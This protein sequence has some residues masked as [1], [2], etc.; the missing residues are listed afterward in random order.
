[1]TTWPRTSKRKRPKEEL[2]IVFTNNGFGEHSKAPAKR[3]PQATASLGT[4]SGGSSLLFFFL[5]PPITQEARG[6]NE[7]DL[8]ARGRSI[9]PEAA[10]SCETPAAMMARPCC[11]G[12]FITQFSRRGAHSPPPVSSY[13]RTPQNA[14]I[15]PVSNSLEPS[16][17]SHPRGRWPRVKRGDGLSLLPSP[18]PHHFLTVAIARPPGTS[19]Q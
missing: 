19:L 3:C 17:H 9:W 7:R 4:R 15:A 8:H 12:H 14:E 16:A 6:G 1:M 13:S 11:R 18:T 2:K 10:R 5:S